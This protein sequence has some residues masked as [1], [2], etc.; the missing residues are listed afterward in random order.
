[1]VETGFSRLSLNESERAEQ[2]E[3]NTKGWAIQLHDLLEYVEGL[4]A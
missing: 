2:F 3:S 4:S 1:V